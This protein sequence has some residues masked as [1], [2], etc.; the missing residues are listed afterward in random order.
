MFTLHH[1]QPQ[2]GALMLGHARM[3]H[4]HP[5]AEALPEPAD[6][7]GGE[8]DLRQQ[9]EHL[10]TLV[11]RFLDEGDVELGLARGGDAPEQDHRLL[12]ERRTDLCQ[13]L[14]LGR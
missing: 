7:L 6:D 11:Q 4:R 10:A 14:C 8:R 3:G 1:V 2:T 9:V 5:V 13:G 12:E